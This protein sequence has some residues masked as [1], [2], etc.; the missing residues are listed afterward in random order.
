MAAARRQSQLVARRDGGVRS[1][2]RDVLAVRGDDERR[3]RRERGDEARG[4]EEVRVDDVR[5]E[6]PRGSPRVA[7]ERDVALLPTASP[8]DDRTLDLVPAIPSAASRPWTKT[9][10]SGSSG[11]GYICETRRIRNAAGQPRTTWTM[12]RHISSVVPSPQST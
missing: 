3:S 11:P 7:G 4:H 12:P 2:V 6:R 9:P 5:A 10:K 1:R 8:V